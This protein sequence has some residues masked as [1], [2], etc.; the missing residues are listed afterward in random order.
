MIFSNQTAEKQY[1]QLDS[2][3]NGLIPNDINLLIACE[4]QTAVNSPCLLVK[5]NNNIVY[6]QQLTDGVHAIKLPLT[7]TTNTSQ[8]LSI[9]MYGKT[10]RDTI[11][12]NGE[13][14]RDTTIKLLKLN[15]NNYSLLDDYDFFNK[16]FVYVNEHEVEQAPMTGF[17]SNSKLELSFDNPFDV[18]YNSISKKNVSIS[19][20]MRHRAANNIDELVADLE[21]S[22]KKLV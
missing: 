3:I 1:N 20:M 2:F 18:W 7:P 5:F 15:I 17:W 19:S 6:D 16:C 4:S 10:S 21:A 11:V 12:E 9:S 13:I 14:V 8:L 22:L